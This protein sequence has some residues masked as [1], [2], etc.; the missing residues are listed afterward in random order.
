MSS[1]SP[2]NSKVAEFV[3]NL[4]ISIYLLS[5]NNNDN[6]TKNDLLLRA[7]EYAKSLQQATDNLT[8]LLTEPKLISLLNILRSLSADKEAAIRAQSLRCI[9]YCIND[10]SSALLMY[11]LNLDLFIVRG[12]ERESRYMWERMQAFKLLKKLAQIAPSLITRSLMQSLL[13]IAEQPKDD[14]RRVS[15]D[16]LR[17]LT[18]ASPELVAQCNGIRVIIDAILDPACADIANSLTLTLLYLLD[19]ESTR[20]YLRPGLDLVRL[21]AVFTDTTAPDGNERESRRAA[22]HRCLIMIMRSW[23]GILCLT[24]D[25]SALRSLVQVLGLPQS[26]TGASWAREAVF[27]L[28][29]EILQVVRSQD[30]RAQAQNTSAMSQSNKYTNIWVS[31]GPNLL[32]SYV[33]MVLMAF[34]ECGLIETLTQVG[35]S[36][37]PDFSGLATKLLVEILKLSAD[38]L[39]RSVCAQLNSLPLVVSQAAQFSGDDV[40]SRVRALHLLTALSNENF[41]DQLAHTDNTQGLLSLSP[42]L[43][44]PNN[45]HKDSNSA[46]HDSNT[47]GGNHARNF[48]S[49]TAR[50]MSSDTFNGSSAGGGVSSG[51]PQGRSAAGLVLHGIRVDKYMRRTDMGIYSALTRSNIV[52]VM[53]HHMD[54]QMEDSELQILLKKSQ[55]LASKDFHQWDW[56]MIMQLLEGPLTSTP[57]ILA[58]MKTKFLK[59]L[60]SFLRPTKQ[61]FCELDWNIPNMKFVKIA[62]LLFRCL[63]SCEVGRTYEFFVN[64]IDEIFDNLLAEI[65]TGKKSNAISS[66]DVTAGGTAPQKKGSTGSMGL[67]SG[68]KYPSLSSPVGS[69]Q[70]NKLS[71]RPMSRYSTCHRLSR[72]YFLL[73]GILSSSNYGMTYFDKFHLYDGLYSL[74]KDHSKDYITRLLASHLD[75]NDKRARTLLETWTKAGSIPFRKFVISML[76]VNIRTNPREY[77][78]AM[79]IISSQLTNSDPGLRAATL[80]VLEEAIQDSTCLKVLIKK[81]PQFNLFGSAASLNLQLSFLSTI[82]G[83]EYLKSIGWIQQQ[84]TAWLNEGN[85]KYVESVESSL[86]SAL[87]IGSKQATAA[88]I[89]ENPDIEKTSPEIEKEMKNDRGSVV[90][91]SGQNSSSGTTGASDEGEEAE[92]TA[93]NFNPSTYRTV[94]DDYFFTRIHELPW[95][96]ELYQEYSSGRRVEIS[97]EC[98]VHSSSIELIDRSKIINEARR[99]SDG[100]LAATS[101]SAAATASSA[102][103]AQ[104]DGSLGNIQAYLSVNIL[105]SDG[106]PK[107]F[108]VESNCTL[109]ARISLGSGSNSDGAV[110]NSPTT[111]ASSPRLLTSPSS[112]AAN[113]TV[114]ASSSTLLANSFVRSVS[115]LDGSALGGGNSA[116]TP[117]DSDDSADWASKYFTDQAQQDHL[118]KPSHREQSNL[119]F[120]GDAPVDGKEKVHL[121]TILNGESEDI[122]KW[123]FELDCSTGIFALGSLLIPLPLPATVIPCVCLTKHLYGELAKTKLGAQ[124]IEESG[125]IQQ[126]TQIIKGEVRAAGPGGKNGAARKEDINSFPPTLD[127]RAALWAIGQIGSSAAGFELLQRSDIVEFISHQAKHCPTLSMRGN[128]FYILGLL[129]RS[130]RAR[131]KLSELGW[132]FAPHPHVCAVV[133]ASSTALSS[134]LSIPQTNWVGGWALDIANIYGVKPKKLLN[135]NVD[136]EDSVEGILMHISN[137][138]NHVTQK[139]SLNS[140]RAMKANPRNQQL[141]SSTQLYFDTLKLMCCYY[142]RLPARRFLLYDL[143]SLVQFTPETLRTFDQPF[144]AATLNPSL[145]QKQLPKQAKIEAPVNLPAAFKLPLEAAVAELQS[146][147]PARRP[148]VIK[149]NLLPDRESIMV[150]SRANHTGRPVIPDKRASIVGMAPSSNRKSS[151]SV[152]VAIEEER[153]AAPPV[154]K[155]TPL[156]AVPVKPTV[157]TNHTNHGE[158][159]ANFPLSPK[160][161]IPT[162]PPAASI[163]TAIRYTIS[164]PRL[165]ASNTANSAETYQHQANSNNT[166][167][168]PI[169][170]RA[171]AQPELPLPPAALSP[172][173]LTP[174]K[175][176]T[177]STAGPIAPLTSLPSPP[178]VPPMPTSVPASTTRPVSPVQAANPQLSLSN[179]ATAP[180]APASVANQPRLPL[181]PAPASM[182]VNNSNYP[183][184]AL[185]KSPTSSA[186]NFSSNN[187]NNL[188]PTVSKPALPSVPA[189]A[190]PNNDKK[191]VFNNLNQAANGSSVTPA[192]PSGSSTATK[193]ASPTAAA[194]NNPSATPSTAQFG[195]SLASRMAAFQSGPQSPLNSAN[196]PAATAAGSTAAARPTVVG[197]RLKELSAQFNK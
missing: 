129:A 92:F 159:S 76:R 36:N 69:G 71:H 46:N 157:S 18:L 85:I 32:H 23:T 87:S 25:V 16:L 107:P 60:L 7:I 57:N 62:C 14:F 105:D 138:C 174:L 177:A 178:P 24:S 49:M 130:D 116:N 170:P 17:E 45:Q 135:S 121:Y 148:T 139:A 73:I 111:E 21:L 112:R 143:F 38:L 31:A 75:Y 190:T 12:L 137:L 15:L 52:E 154:I 22:A 173:P 10:N 42:T 104:R 125:H 141:F 90:E 182:S 27:D 164:G 103:A 161:E 39:P 169:Q 29:F 61:M 84:L 176:L 150:G 54:A 68:G 167:P 78:W 63:L 26:V 86:V 168:L 191:F 179:H 151:Q 124:I 172:T 192:S 186:A 2:I 53:R 5:N 110:P 80:S 156:P 195:S 133:P 184:P 64:C 91:S 171:I 144:G 189:T 99:D 96:V 51:E 155:P 1:S 88:A 114:S 30:L 118:C 70:Q 166:A 101:A 74:S 185:A 37:D 79:G 72:A 65:R 56:A 158:S 9:R 58:A 11:K 20:K 113:L 152:V 77:V 146:S 109:R 175:T 183:S 6:R 196:N 117:L 126:F 102:E 3:K 55:V 48:G 134:F 115:T 94:L 67:A 44:E 81:K 145:Q 181:P 149:P 66:E 34:I 93:W 4:E 108:R 106:F 19:T 35:C 41:L 142:Y 165:S 162:R 50:R 8:V 47:N 160:P 122:C 128:C 13:A 43:A 153:S 187:S 100:M 59:R 163:S 98:Y 97:N 197:N 83:V 131:E 180:L 193:L 188:P 123:Q 127:R 147:L 82:T 140:L 132:S 33:V 136:D 28:L 89:A 194:V 95:T 120:E 119:T 40:S